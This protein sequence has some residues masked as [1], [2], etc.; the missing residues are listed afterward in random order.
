MRR[1]ALL[2]LCT[3]CSALRGAVIDEGPRGLAPTPAAPGQSLSASDRNGDG[4]PDLFELRLS[5]QTPDGADAPLQRREQDLDFDGRIDVVETFDAEGRRL[6]EAF[7]LD[8][9]GRIDST[10]HFDQGELARKELSHDASGAVD[11]VQHYVGG[12]LVRIERD[13]NRDGRV[14]LWEYW[15]SDRIDRIGEDLDGD[16]EVDRWTRQPTD[17]AGR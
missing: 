4:R 17:A 16:G 1:L 9:D 3:A 15:E 10:S 12:H 11:V 6:T 14:D 2:M 8:F 13:A 5:G 7:D